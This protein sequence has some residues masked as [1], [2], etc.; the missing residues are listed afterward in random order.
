[1]AFDDMP[2]PW[3]TLHKRGKNIAEREM[4]AVVLAAYTFRDRLPNSMIH[5]TTDNKT[6]V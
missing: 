6:V 3:N 2:S 1:M 4:F 5:F